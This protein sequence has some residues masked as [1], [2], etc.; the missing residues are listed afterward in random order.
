M[1]DC[2]LFIVCTYGICFGFIQKC[3]VIYSKL[4]YLS[5]MSECEYCTGFWSGLIA[6][7]LIYSPVLS[8]SWGI[9]T[10]AVAHAFA[11]AALCYMIDTVY[12]KLE[13]DLQEED[14]G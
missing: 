3:E 11:G 2:L 4:S 8:Y 1:V 9:I 6:F 5:R 13:Y 12:K 7:F 14:N 10:L